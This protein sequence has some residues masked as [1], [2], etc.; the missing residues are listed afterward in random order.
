MEGKPVEAG[1]AG[2]EFEVAG[3]V[4]AVAAEAAAVGEE[5][6]AGAE[7]EVLGERGGYVDADAGDA[8]LYGDGGCGEGADGFGADE[9]LRRRG[10][11]GDLSWRGFEVGAWW[12]GGRGRGGGGG[13]RD[14]F[15]SN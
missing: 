1:G 7:V 13:F 8:E 6:A 9:S 12:K 15:G 3:D 14:R 2:T 5:A 11:G 10:R 4:D